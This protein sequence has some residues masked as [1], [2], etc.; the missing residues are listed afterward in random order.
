MSAYTHIKAAIIQGIYEPGMRLTEEYLAN[1]IQT[2]RTPIREAIQHLEAEG[3]ITPLKKGVIVRSF[4]KED[5]QQI[6]DLRGLLEGYAVSHA[7][8][9]R[10]SENLVVLE[11]SLTSF[12]GL[13][14][15]EYQPKNS[16]VNKIMQ[17]NTTF[18]EAILASSKNEHLQFL[19]SKVIVLPL[20]FR[21][22]YWY[23]KEETINSFKSH[24]TIYQAIKD[25]DIDRARTA[26]LEH[27]YQ[28][29]DCALK[30]IEQRKLLIEKEV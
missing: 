7:A 4:T 1:E 20:V 5:I 26:M 14:Q 2:S 27:I 9:N 22:F 16:I 17:E 8:R 13:I 30:N 10:T 12:S 15:K 21:S 28:G 19:L 23:S 24:Q 25:Q 11:N 6:Y 29:R 3:L 18:H